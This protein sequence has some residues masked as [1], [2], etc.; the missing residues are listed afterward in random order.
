MSSLRLVSLVSGLYDVVLGLSLLVAARPMAALFGVP[1]PQ[2]PVFGDTNGLFL[3]GIGIG[4]W[5]AFRDPVTWRPYL[6]LMGPGLKGA[7]AAIF[8]ADHFARH[9]PASFLAFAVTDGTL[10]VWTLWAL[11]RSRGG[12]V[13]PN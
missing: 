10:A 6:W 4:Y 12:V 2:P 8:L 3:L 13:T 11:L 1:A 7:G 5:F 9:S